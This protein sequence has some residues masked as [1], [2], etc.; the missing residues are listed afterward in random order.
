MM[1]E[2]G[3]VGKGIVRAGLVNADEHTELGRR[4]GIDHYPTVYLFPLNK[5]T[6]NGRILSKGGFAATD[7]DDFVR[8]H[9]DPD[10]S[11]VVILTDANFDELV[12]GNDEEDWFIEFYA[13][14]CGHC[15]KL[16]PEWEELATKMRR[17]VKI[18]KVDA[19]S[20]KK[21]EK[22]FKIEFFP[23]LKL[24]KK[25]TVEDEEAVP[26]KGTQQAEAMQIWLE[27]ELG[28]PATFMR[29]YENSEVI[30]LHDD[31]F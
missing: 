27:D 29:N 9:L 5:K 8:E 31:D 4:M 28:L 18:G 1:V 13:P 26:H 7:L 22:R 10:A 20:N 11:D 21:L 12:Y 3:K 23:T 15:K 6:D 19:T 2:R 17:K 16:K 14:W 30:V 25:D 24:F